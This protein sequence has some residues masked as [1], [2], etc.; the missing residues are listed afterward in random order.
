VTEGQFWKDLRARINRRTPEDM[1]FK[2]PGWCD[3]FDPKSYASRGALARIVGRVNFVHRGQTEKWR[4]TLIVNHM[5]ASFEEFDWS[6][7]EPLLPEDD[8]TGWIA[9]DGERL[10]IELPPLDR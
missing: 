10:T 5:I 2:L 4:F 1:G 9:V 8:E 3:W 7:L 6:E